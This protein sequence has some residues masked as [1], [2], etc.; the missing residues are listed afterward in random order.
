MQDILRQLE[1]CYERDKEILDKYKTE[2]QTLKD[3]NNNLKRQI[4]EANENKRKFS[5]ID[6]MPKVKKEE[7]AKPIVLENDRQRIAVIG[8]SNLVK[9]LVQNNKVMKFKIHDE[10]VCIVNNQTDIP[11]LNYDDFVKRFQDRELDSV[12][13]TAVS[14]KENNRAAQ[15]EIAYQE[16]VRGKEKRAALPGH[17][18]R[19]CE[20]F[21]EALDAENLSEAEKLKMINNCSRHRSRFQVPATPPHYWSLP[22]F[23][24]PNKSPKPKRSI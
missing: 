8:N 24:T 10:V 23:S 21:Y 7:K 5:Q 4:T 19:E 2:I 18:C 15:N 6:S 11:V 1:R 12:D 20:D 16:V 17:T 14:D 13:I 9:I 3:E 22:S